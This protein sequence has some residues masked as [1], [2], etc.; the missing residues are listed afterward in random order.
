M[1]NVSI[2]DKDASFEFRRAESNEIEETF[3]SAMSKR[4]YSQKF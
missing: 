2:L 4:R 3:T 1:T